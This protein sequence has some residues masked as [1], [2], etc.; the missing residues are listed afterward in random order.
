MISKCPVCGG[1][2]VSS[3]TD[4]IDHTLV[5]YEYKCSAGHYFETFAYGYYEVAVLHG[6][7]FR[8]WRWLYSTPSEEVRQFEKEIRE[9]SEEVAAS[10]RELP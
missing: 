8:E 10:I 6:D 2:L 5:E 9:F 1:V 4:Y 3:Y 7:T